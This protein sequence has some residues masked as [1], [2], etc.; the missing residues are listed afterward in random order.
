MQAAALA[1][2]GAVTPPG[3][4]GSWP[5]CSVRAGPRQG[6]SCLA[7]AREG[8]GVA[9]GAGPFSSREDGPADLLAFPLLAAAV[10]RSGLE[11]QKMG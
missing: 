6:I 10:P 8:N 5:E 2:V 4:W 9:A 7:R 11:N 3:P 1:G